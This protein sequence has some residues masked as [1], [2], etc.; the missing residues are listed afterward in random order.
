MVNTIAEPGRVC[1]MKHALQGLEYNGK[2]RQA[3]VHYHL[4]C[5][6]HAVCAALLLSLGPAWAG[7]LE[8]G[9]AAL[10]RGDYAD[11]LKTLRPLAA[12]GDAHAQSHLGVM[13]ENGR[14]VARHYA[15]ALK[16]YRLAAAQGL[17]DAQLALGAMYTSGH[18]VARDYAE[19]VK[20][21]RLA[22]AQDDAKA[23]FALGSMYDNGRGV[24]RDYAEALKWYRLAAAHGDANAQR[25]LAELYYDGQGVTQD[26]IRAHMW[27]SLS[28]ASGDAG[29]VKYRDMFAKRMTPQQ[30]AEAQKLARECQQRNLKG[31]E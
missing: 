11:A 2:A 13:Y 14:G 7:P 9:V 19:A 26:Y 17:A 21:Y 29:A 25:N 22:A 12:Q 30:I 3:R 18:G 16:W 28:A 6:I 31:C 15:E 10:N 20:W 1:E 23:Q 27:L 4:N 8:D 5:L 24:A